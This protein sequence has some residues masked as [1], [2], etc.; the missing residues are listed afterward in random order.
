MDALR[1]WLQSSPLNVAI[2]VLGTL[3]VGFVGWKLLKGVLKVLLILGLLAGIAAAIF[4][5][6]GMG[7]IRP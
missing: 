4:W 3:F 5:L 6:R 7:P 2:V 1:D